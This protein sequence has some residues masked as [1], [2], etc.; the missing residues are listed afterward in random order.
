MFAQLDYAPIGAFGLSWRFAEDATKWTVLPDEDLAHFRPLTEACS[1][2]LWGEFIAPGNGHLVALQVSAAAWPF[3][4]RIAKY[5]TTDD[6]SSAEE[7][8]RVGAFLEQHIQVDRASRVLFFW[9]ASC[10]VDTTWDVLLRYW[11]DFCYPSDD[12]NVVVLS[13]SDILIFYT[14]GLVS[15]ARRRAV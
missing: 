15:L 12:S 7:T 10:A 2:R 13:E 3:G 14:E 8:N 4:E 11:S 9:S 5:S 6:W 1:R